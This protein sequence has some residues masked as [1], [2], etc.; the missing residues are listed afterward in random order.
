M[1]GL[2]LTALPAAAQSPAPAIGAPNELPPVA[3]TV[4][5][6][7]PAA[8]DCSSC[9]FDF[10]KVPPA[11]PHP[12]PGYFTISP[13][14]CGYY[15]FLDMLQ[16]NCREKPPIMPYGNFG[17]YQPSF[18]D[19]DFRYLD[20]PDN[21]QHD[22][23]DPLKRMRLGDNWLLS[24]G[25]QSWFRQM[26]EVDRQF[27]TGND[28]YGLLRSRLYGD[29]WYKDQV[30]FF[31]EFLYADAFW[32][33]VNP[34]PID[35]NR[36]D[37]LNL[38]VEFKTI[39]VDGAPVNVRVGR[40]EMLFGSQRLIS[41]LDWANTRR[42]FQGV[43]AYRTEEHFDVDLFWVQPVVVDRNSFDSVDNN[44]NFA[45]IWTT[46][47]PR[48]GTAVD[49]YYL[50]LDNTNNVARGSGGVTQGFTAHTIGT[51]YSGD[52][53]HV[54]WDFE[55][56]LQLGEW[57]NQDLVAGAATAGLGYHFA[58]AP[59]NP[60]FWVYYDWASGESTPGA[61]GTR[62]TFQQ[63]FPFGHYYFGFL[64]L[65]GRQNIQDVSCQTVFYPA[66]WVTGI[67]Q[68][69]RF[70]LAE[71]GDALYNAAGRAIRN[72]PT[73]SSGRDVGCE[74]DLVLSFHLSAHSDFLLGYSK[75]YRGDFIQNTGPAVSPELFYVQYGYRW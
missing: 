43:R 18:F 70:W 62:S 20:K 69:H 1:A 35:I 24:T 17:F 58:D 59:M 14:G 50:M 44:Q 54:L 29:L 56:M 32:H 36:S 47:K 28:S 39:E 3:V 12:R 26:N 30:R 42:T 2:S 19:S 38:F 72:D 4:P 64:D 25:G 37:F 67:V 9:Q 51:R 23:M 68:F 15:S 46:Y 22:Y 8:C 48:K 11:R 40:Q 33:D 52:C 13:T 49:L 7:T 6:T 45:G 65:V 71:A 63:L 5:V 66:P 53:N 74:L 16:G 57:A 73:G 10:S 27:S 34:A 61:G 60:Q 41:T 21:K 55:G 75:L 31:A